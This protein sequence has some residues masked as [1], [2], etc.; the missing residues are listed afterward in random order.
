MPHHCSIQNSP[1]APIYFRVKVK[2]HSMVDKALHDLDLLYP[3][4][5][6]YLNLKTLDPV[7][8]IPLSLLYF[9]F[10]P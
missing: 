10:Y 2:I 4:D 5:V 3:I 7:L 8:L 9:F 6:I 1:V